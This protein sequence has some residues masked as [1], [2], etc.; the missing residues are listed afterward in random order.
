ME[1]DFGALEAQLAQGGASV[2][3]VMAEQQKEAVESMATNLVHY[4]TKLTEGGIPAELAAD[5][6]RSL[7]HAMIAMTVNATAMEAMRKLHEAAHGED[8]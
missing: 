7:D 4:Y 2:A 1:P 8:D 6:T 5:L 3:Q